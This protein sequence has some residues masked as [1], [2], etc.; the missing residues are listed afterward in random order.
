MLP[1]VVA[2]VAGAKVDI[3]RER[4]SREIVTAEGEKIK[5]ENSKVRTTIFLTDVENGK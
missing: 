3:F 4:S 2:V 1:F 5:M